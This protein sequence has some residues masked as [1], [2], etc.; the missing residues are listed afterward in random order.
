[1]TQFGLEPG[2]TE[3]T[4][5][6]GRTV[7]SKVKVERIQGLSNDLALALAASPIRI[8]AP[9]PGKAVVGVEVPNSTPAIVGLRGVLESPEYRAQRSPLA[10]GWGGTCPETVVAD[11][12]TLPHLL[13]AGSTGSGKSVCVNSLIACLL[14]R[15]SPEMLRL[16]MVDPKRVARGTTA[17]RTCWRPSWWTWRGWWCVLQWLL[18]EMDQRYERLAAAGARNIDGFNARV[19]ARGEATMPLHRLPDRRARRPG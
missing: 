17:F 15:N 3:R 14:C 5:R 6:Q 18:R 9:V 10:V 2:F 8:E 7:R 19:A 11:L 1:M 13:I 12:G 16:L 4:N